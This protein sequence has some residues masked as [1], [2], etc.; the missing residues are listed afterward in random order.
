[1]GFMDKILGKDDR[2]YAQEFKDAYVECLNN[3]INFVRCDAA[4]DIFDAWM[5]YDPNHNDAN[6]NYA[7]AIVFGSLANI[8]MK[9]P[10]NERT[11]QNALSTARKKKPKDD[12]LLEWYQQIA[13]AVVGY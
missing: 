5:K 11:V 12:S 10:K 2:N 9:D 6:L 4:K 3:Q 7:A 1:M 8:Q 13:N